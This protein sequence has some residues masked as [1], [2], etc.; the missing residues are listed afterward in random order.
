MKVKISDVAKKAGVSTATVDRVL[1]N[2]GGVKK[3]TIEHVQKAIE[4]LGFKPNRVARRLAK[5]SLNIGF[6]L[7]KVQT[8]FMDNLS[9]FICNEQKKMAAESVF[10]HLEHIDLW[11]IDAP[12]LLKEYAKNLDG[13]AVVA[14]E[15][16]KFEQSIDEISEEIPVVTLVSDAPNSQRLAYI[17]IDNFT[18][19][20]TAAGLVGRFLTPFQASKV[21]L[22]MGSEALRD[23]AERK[24]G[25]EEAIFEEYPYLH[26]LSPVYGYDDHEKVEEQLSA[27]LNTHEDIAAIY[28]LSA[29]N[30]GVLD[31]LRKR[32]NLQRK[33]Y[34]IVHDMTEYNK[35]A[36][37]SGDFDVILSQQPKEGVRRSIE[38]LIDVLENKKTP[39][40]QD[41]LNIGI[42]LRDNLPA[43]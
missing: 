6:I 37:I 30:R 23:H 5:P 28:C 35:K 11:N 43:E 13:L 15:N 36:L 9:S 3:E 38:I 1:N 41:K 19:G 22:V 31:A 24:A 8:H 33:I 4:E 14:I 34:V 42:Y 29:G 25:F 39:P 2:R 20:R 40:F 27:L 7:P 16:E 32:N 26:I 17:G 12:A 21:A 18:A 10:I